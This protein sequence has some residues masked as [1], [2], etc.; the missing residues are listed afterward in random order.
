DL[1]RSLGPRS[2]FLS[3]REGHDYSQVPADIPRVRDEGNCGPLGAIIA[4]LAAGTSPRLLVLAVDMPGVTRQLLGE[5]LSAGQNATG[6]VPTHPD[7]GLHEPL[8]A[9]YPRLPELRAHLAAAQAR[10]AFS[11]QPLLSEVI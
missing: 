9:V 5:L 3:I 10:G 4:A 7:S 2:L 11:L 6:T 8:C 1:L